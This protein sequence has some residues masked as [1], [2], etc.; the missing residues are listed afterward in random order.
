MKINT[1][2]LGAAAAV[3]FATP[4]SAA[5]TF[6]GTSTVTKLNASDPGLVLY[7]D[8]LDFGPFTLD[9]DSATATP[10]S[11]TASLL[12]IGTTETGVNLGEDTKSFEIA[13]NFVF[14]S[15]SGVTGPLVTGTTTGIWLFDVGIV[16]W[17]SPV[18]FDFGD[19]GLLKLTLDDVF[20]DTPGE[21]T[22]KGTFKLLS[23]P[24]PAVPE[25]ATWAMMIAGMGAVGMTMRRRNMS[26]RF[27]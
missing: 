7:A 18:F 4:V 2:L 5:V 14:D 26:I 22:V 1:L 20:F 11:F 10:R 23:E 15:P 6:E 9:T 3:V 8:P 13:L 16:H 21:A 27:A 24:T 17:T 19:T 25:A 12:K